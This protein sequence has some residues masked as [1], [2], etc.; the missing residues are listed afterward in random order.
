MRRTGQNAI[1]ER[2]TLCVPRIAIS[3][4]PNT[5]VD[6]TMESGVRNMNLMG[7]DTDDWSIFLVEFD[8]FKEIFATDYNIV[9][10]LIP[11]A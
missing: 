5:G 10:K 11:K 2:E 8:D 9:I 1:R 7:I 3:F 6:G 4:V